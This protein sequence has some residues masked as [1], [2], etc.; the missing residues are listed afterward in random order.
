MT[1][2]TTAATLAYRRSPDQDHRAAAHHPVVIVGAGP[3]GLVLAL[4]LAAKGRRS[5]VIDRRTQLSDGSRAI[6]WSKRTLE[7]MGRLGLADDLVARGVTW[8]TG[9]VFHRDREVYA[10]DLLPEA[11]HQR[12]A[13]IN[14]QQFYFEA[15][16]IAA[17]ER[18][19]L[20]DLRW[21]SEVTA[22][23][24]QGD[25]AR[26]SIATPEGSYALTCDWLIA[27][28]GARSMVRQSLGLGFIGQTFDDQFLICDIKMTVD[29]PTERWF[30]FDPPFN[31]GR[32]ALLHRQADDVW[33]L[34]FQIGTHADRDEEM[35]PQNVARRVRAMLGEIDF[36][37]EWISC[38]RF[39]CRRL[40]NF[41]HGR[42]LFVGDAAH[43]VSPFGARGGNSG[44]Q[45]AD[46]LAW[47]LDL[48]LAGTAPAALLDSYGIERQQA[49]DE[50][51][52]NSTRATDF[53]APKGPGATALRDAVLDLAAREPF[54]RRLLNSGR[55][56]LPTTYDG[57]PLNSADGFD[58][59]DTPAVRPG[60]PASDAPDMD[61][62]LLARLGAGFTLLGVW[63]RDRPPPEGW[64]ASAQH[65][66]GCH[67]T[68][69][70]AHGPEARAR[71][72]AVDAP[73]IYLLRPDQHVAA[74]WRACDPAVIASAVARTTHNA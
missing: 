33:R 25:G 24:A 40:E 42:V 53:I 52:L 62:W 8:Q 60:A 35:R 10:F 7:I 43:Q 17:A 16:C 61:S 28:D 13:F 6:C 19:G 67:I 73:A 39:Q 34:D 30:W 2:P 5:V 65:V 45:D 50:N 71:Y 12:P 31:P 59:G 41:R 48:V 58:A 69:V 70:V 4:D 44:I 22:L 11:G 18:S 15:A 14:L 27:A 49:A 72:G 74:R 57:S 64:P 3:V 38:Y 66:A 21:A 1:T 63:D 23:Q 37:F 20:V 36:T 9:K 56:S 46:N 54:A 26:L 51:I 29:R 68:P 55:L 47:K 32:S